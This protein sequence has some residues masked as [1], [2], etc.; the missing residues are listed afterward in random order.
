MHVRFFLSF[1]Y[2]DCAALFIFY[3]VDKNFRNGNFRMECF[4]CIIV[5]CNNIL[6]I[7]LSTLRV[8]TALQLNK[9]HLSD[10]VK[11]VVL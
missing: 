6:C 1:F 11:L 5:H 3:T 10:I 8:M 7:D 9:D 2:M 4:I